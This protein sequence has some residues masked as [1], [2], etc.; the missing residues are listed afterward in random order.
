MSIPAK[1]GNSLKT[2]ISEKLLKWLNRVPDQ[3]SS[4]TMLEITSKREDYQA[5]KLKTS[6]LLVKAR[7]MLKGLVTRL[8]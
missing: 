4:P 1:S 3:K 7:K 6:A 8:R 2:L 5:P